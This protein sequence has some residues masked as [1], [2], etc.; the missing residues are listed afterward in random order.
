M[1]YSVKIQQLNNFATDLEKSLIN[2]KAM[3]T[4][5]NEKYIE[6]RVRDIE[7]LRDIAT[8]FNAIEPLDIWLELLRYFE[9]YQ[10]FEKD[11]FTIYLPFR[12]NPRKER[13]ILIDLTK[14]GGVCHG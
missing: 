3:N 2:Y 12:T 4:N 1:E 13:F 14:A 6:K 5:P 9:H 11:G 7:I 10:S 8:S